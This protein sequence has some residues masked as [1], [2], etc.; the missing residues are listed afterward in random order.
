MAYFQTYPVLC[1][2]GTAEVTCS[3]VARLKVRNACLKRA[4]KLYNEQMSRY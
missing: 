2:I 4:K 3:D 1:K